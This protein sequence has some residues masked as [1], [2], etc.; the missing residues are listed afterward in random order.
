MLSWEYPP[1]VVGGLGAHVAHLA[2]EL[3]R[4]GVHVHVVSPRFKDG[5]VEEVQNHLAVSRVDGEKHADDFIENTMAVNDYI[6]GRGAA[7]VGTQ[8]GPWLIHAHDWLVGPAATR[9]KADYGLPLIGTIHA[10]EHGRN[11]GIHTDLQARIHHEEWRLANEA[12]ELIACSRFMAHQIRDVFQVPSS[13]LE[14]IANGVDVSRLTDA[15]FDRESFRREYAGEHEK[16]VLHVGR[17]VAEKGIYVVLEA[18]PKLL[19]VVPRAK[20]IVVGSGPSLDDARERAS[21]TGWSDR[22]LFTGFVSDE[23]RNRLYQVAD[24][25][26]FP[27]LYEPFGI[28]ALEAM[29]L[30]V[31]VVS[32]NAG[33][34]AEVVDREETG[35]VVDAGSANSLAWGIAHVLEQPALSLCRA[36]RAR[37]KANTEFTWDVIADRT[38]AKYE[39][40]LARTLIG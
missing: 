40:L 11:D 3:A 23:I 30:G 38:K 33:G 12:D 35:V 27:S 22:L 17:L 9:L 8:P 29:A 31:P 26:I 16:I 13:K 18:I 37:T 4:Q 10:T 32:S 7:I 24:V 21:Q 6:Y 15:S 25:A 19:E 36:E 28:V 1:F 14:V 20:F 39:R 5:A 2:P 34:L